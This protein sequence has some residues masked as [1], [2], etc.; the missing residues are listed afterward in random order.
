VKEIKRER[1]REEDGRD[2][3]P[4]KKSLLVRFKIAGLSRGVVSD[5]IDV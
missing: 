4:G 2:K 5:L 3:S 1:T